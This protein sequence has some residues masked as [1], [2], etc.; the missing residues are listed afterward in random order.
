MDPNDVSSK[1]IELEDRS[2]LNNLRTCHIAET[3]N[4]TWEDCEIKMRELIKSKL[5]MNEHIETDRCHRL[6]RKKNQNRP[7]TIISRETKNLKKRKTFEKYGIFIYED[8]CK[9][10]M[11]LRKETWQEVLEYKRQNKFGYLN[12]RSM[13]FG[14]MGEIVK[15]VS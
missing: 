4:K 6:L 8:F 1:L 2:R 3:L 11:E 5:K 10:T 9:D 14:I 7:S 13:V 12:Y 15:D